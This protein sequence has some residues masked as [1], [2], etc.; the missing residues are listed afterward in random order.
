MDDPRYL[1]LALAAMKKYGLSKTPTI[2]ILDGDDLLAKFEGT[3]KTI[4]QT[5]DYLDENRR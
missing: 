2:I 4:K 5:R 3:V 1:S